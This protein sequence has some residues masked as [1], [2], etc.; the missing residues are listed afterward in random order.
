MGTGLSIRHGQTVGPL[1]DRAW[2]VGG[3]RPH[4]H[5]THNRPFSLTDELCPR[6]DPLP[7][8]RS[9]EAD[10]EFGSKGHWFGISQGARD[11]KPEGGI[12]A[13]K[14]SR[15]GNVSARSDVVGMNLYFGLCMVRSNRGTFSPSTWPMVFEHLVDQGSGQR[16]PRFPFCILRGSLSLVWAR[17][18]NGQSE[19]RFS[20]LEYPRPFL[21]T[22]S[23]LTH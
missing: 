23:I 18:V 10:G 20:L 15:T 19:A 11:H 14:L 12:G 17:R 5:R 7:F 9:Q 16:H 3:F 1:S 13:G 6:M 8:G 2:T 22:R 21:R 4:G